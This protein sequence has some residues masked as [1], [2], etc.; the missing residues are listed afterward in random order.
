MLFFILIGLAA[1]FGG[2]LFIAMLFRRVVAA[3]EVHIIQSSNKTTSFGKDTPNGN[4]YYEWPSSLPFFGVEKVV[5]PVSVFELSIDGYEAYDVGRVPFVVDLTSFFR[6]SDTN[7]AAQRVSSFKDLH[8]QLEAI[9]KGAARSILASSDIEEI[10][11]ARATFGDKFT[12]E[13]ASQLEAWGVETVKN[14]ELMDIRDSADDVVIRNIMEKKKSLIEKESRQEVALN[15]KAARIKE[16]EAQREVDI[17]AQQAQ[18]AVGLRTVEQERAVELAREEKQQLVKEQ[19][20]LTKEKEMAVQQVA[21]VKAADIEKEVQVVQAQ[22]SKE[23]Q[24]IEAEGKLESAKLQAQAHLEVKDK[25]SQ[26]IKL[27][28]LAKAEAKEKMEVATVASQIELAKEIGSNEGYQQYLISIRQVEANEQ[29]GVTQADALKAADIKIIA[30]TES[31]TSGI[32]DAT[33][34][35]SS[36]GGQQVG[37]ALEGLA[38]TPLGK[39]FL[40]KFGLDDDESF[41]SPVANAQ[42]D[43]LNKELSKGKKKKG[44]GNSHLNGAGH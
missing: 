26:G 19:Q 18:E 13:V 31:A 33:E 36:K 1:L 38:N 27:E 40:N 29:I 16:I 44:K 11:E 22:Q 3:N 6:I 24:V 34:V 17:Q 12:K 2:G 23:T 37:A 41:A 5:L 4:V 14:I 25:E 39:K 9:V 10:M 15:K 32:H 20:R 35:F 28:G 21:D 30:N 7:L 8:D 43:T 42:V